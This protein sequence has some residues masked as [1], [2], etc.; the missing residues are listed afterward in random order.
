[1]TPKQTTRGLYGMPFWH[2]IVYRLT[3]YPFDIGSIIWRPQI[4]NLDQLP[5]E[6]P[7]LLLGNHSSMLDPFWAGIYIPRCQSHGQC[8]RPQCAISW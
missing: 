1:M 2:G 4:K 8:C 5:K 3:T 6:E 7:Y